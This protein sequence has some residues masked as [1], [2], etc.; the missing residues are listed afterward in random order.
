MPHALPSTQ[1]ALFPHSE[2]INVF[3]MIH[4]VHVQDST[5]NTYT[6]RAPW[7]SNLDLNIVLRHFRLEQD[8]NYSMRRTLTMFNVFFQGENGH[9][10]HPVANVPN[11]Q[12]KTTNKII[13][14]L[15]WRPY[16]NL[17][18]TTN[19]SFSRSSAK[20]HN[21][22]Q[23][24]QHNLRAPHLDTICQHKAIWPREK[25][26]AWRHCLVSPLFHWHRHVSRVCNP[27]AAPKSKTTSGQQANFLSICTAYKSSDNNSTVQLFPMGPQYNSLH[28]N[29]NMPRLLSESLQYF[30][31][32]NVKAGNK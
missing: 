12:V 13:Y 26:Q 1:S 9:V 15:G 16:W 20:R 32:L 28:C 19:S 6:T 22:T 11:P 8:K 25:P 2:R 27:A 30:T 5:V 3:R 24:E 4:I 17:P 23:H 21:T 18:T 10:A 31:L 14:N 29:V 7:D